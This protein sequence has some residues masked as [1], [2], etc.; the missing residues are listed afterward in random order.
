[1]NFVSFELKRL[2]KSSPAKTYRWKVYR[3]RSSPAAFIGAIV[4]TDEKAAI[5]AAIE[6]FGIEN[7]GQQKR[8]LAQR[9]Y[10]NP[11]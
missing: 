1:V 6:E 8:L 4:A 9:D 5:T 2:A 10:N 7:P 11:H 3:L